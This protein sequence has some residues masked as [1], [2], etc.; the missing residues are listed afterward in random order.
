M[1][2]LL[3]GIHELHGSFLAIGREDK[4]KRGSN[5]RQ[6]AKHLEQSKA[7]VEIAIL[8]C[9]EA[10]P[11]NTEVNVNMPATFEM[12]DLENLLYRYLS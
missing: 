3:Q 5:K 7:Q 6:E 10:V 9:G 12:T 8:D 1:S 4:K 2:G 11:F